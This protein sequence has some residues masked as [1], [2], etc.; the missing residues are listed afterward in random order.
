VSGPLNIPLNKAAD[1]DFGATVG[2][3]EQADLVF[4]NYPTGRYYITARSPA[5]IAVTS[6]P[7][8]SPDQCASQQL[9]TESIFLDQLHVGST[10]CVRTKQGRMSA[11]T[12]TG[13][14][15]S[16]ASTAIFAFHY[17]TWK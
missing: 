9:R 8:T 15:G 3:E 7:A 14:P 4:S 5:Q 2:I 10:L 6:Q 16:N 12:V 13:M 17:T 11:V 1:L